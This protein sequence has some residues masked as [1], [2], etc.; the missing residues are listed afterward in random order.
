MNESL[1]TES[2]SI[3]ALTLTRYE[4]VEPVKSSGLG[5]GG[6][7]VNDNNQDDDKEVFILLAPYRCGASTL[8]KRHKPPETA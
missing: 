1:T 8:R 3:A 5:L 4:R 6:S 7:T 2:L